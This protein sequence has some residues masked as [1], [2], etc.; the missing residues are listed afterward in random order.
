PVGHYTT[1]TQPRGFNL[2]NTGNY[3]ISCGQKSDFVSVSRID[4]QTGALTELASY[5]VGKGAMWVTV[6]TK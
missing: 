4:R 5:P 1:Q 3:L 6:V 2:D